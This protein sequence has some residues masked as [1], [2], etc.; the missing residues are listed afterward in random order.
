VKAKKD[1]FLLS[2]AKKIQ[3]TAHTHGAL[4]SMSTPARI[5][6]PSASAADA[7]WIE[8]TMAQTTNVIKVAIAILIHFG[9]A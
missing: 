4:I 2:G 1:S 5:R 3:I 7:Y 6:L 9:Q 8:M